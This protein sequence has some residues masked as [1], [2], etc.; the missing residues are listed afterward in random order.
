MSNTQMQPMI[1]LITIYGGISA[2]IV[3]DF[4]RLFRK[5]AKNRR[6]TTIVLDSLFIAMLGAIVV[7]VLYFSNSGV[8]RVY[9]ILGLILGF[10]LYLIGISPLFLHIVNRIKN[11]RIKKND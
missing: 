5:L 9:T 8:L 7:L 10:A 4:Y 2:G 1:F 3:Y 11:S 6:W